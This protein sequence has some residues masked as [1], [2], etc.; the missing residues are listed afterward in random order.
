MEIKTPL[1]VYSASAGSGKTFSLVQAYLKLTL[2]PIR[3]GSYF[4]S[5]I[6]MTFTNKASLEMK[7]RIMEALDFLAYPDRSN[8]KEQKKADDLLQTTQKNLQI[9]PQLIRENA[10]KVLSA[11]L[12]SYGEFKVQ[13]IDKFSLQ[14]IRTFSRD[15]NVNDDFEVVLKVNEIVERVVD[16]LLS[17]IGSPEYKEVT[18]LAIRYAKSNLEDGDK[19]NFRTSLIDFAKVLTKEDNQEYVLSILKQSYTKELYQQIQLDYKNALFLFHKERDEL[20]Q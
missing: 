12:H 7:E 20:Y 9:D 4:N 15:L 8:T 3:E 11:I 18:A 13:T 1:E 2:D 16:Q 10:Q 6:A 17:K 19:W 14:L 5:V